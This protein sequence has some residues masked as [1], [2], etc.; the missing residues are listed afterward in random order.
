MEPLRSHMNFFN[1]I[2]AC[3]TTTG[4]AGLPDWA[5]SGGPAWLTQADRCVFYN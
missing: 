2:S 5:W 4:Q 3:P 1:H